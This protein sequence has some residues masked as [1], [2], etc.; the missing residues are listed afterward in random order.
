[1]LKIL[2]LFFGDTGSDFV[3][4]LLLYGQEAGEIIPQMQKVHL[5]Y[6]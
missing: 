6:E 5:F 4:L 3:V 1:M 2:L